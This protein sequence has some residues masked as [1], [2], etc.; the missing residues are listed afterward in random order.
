M[1]IELLAQTEPA[2]GAPTQDLIPA[3]I[4]AVVLSVLV[5]LLTL[6]H[7]SGRITVLHKIGAF[8]TRV[9]GLPPWAAVPAGVVGVSLV[10]AAFGF[11]WDVATHIDNGRDEGPFANPAHFFILAGLGGIA[12]AGILA[13]IIGTDDDAGHTVRIAPGWH[14]PVGGVLLVLCGTIALLGFPLDDV[15]HRLFGQDVTMWGP[16]HLQMI[17][18]ASLA[19]LACWVLVLEGRRT[20]GSG[21]S[22]ERAE[23]TVRFT[24]PL[25]AGAFLI[26]LST[27][28][29]E[30]DFGVPQFRLLY[31]PVLLS[32][33]AGIALVVARVRIG[34]GGALAAVAFFVAFRGALAL[35]IGPGL[36]RSMPHFPLYLVEALAVETVA[37]RVPRERQL[38][39]GL[40]SG[41]LIGTLGVAAEW[42]WSHL[43]MPI[44]WP[45]SLLPEGAVLGFVAGVAGGVLG[46]LLARAL[47]PE[48]LRQPVPRRAG[49]LA[50]VAAVACL[51]IP[52][53]MASPDGVVADVTL[54]DV[55]PGPDRTVEATIAI[56]PADV[57]DGAE[58]LTVTAW[59][60]AEWQDQAVVIDHLERVDEGTW[61]TTEP[62]PVHGKWKAIVRLHAGRT[63][64]AMP[65]FMP[66][67]QAIPAEE[68]PADSAFSRDFVSD[69]ELLQR[70][71]T[72]GA[73]W[74]EWTAYLTILAIAVAWVASIVWGLGRLQH[75]G[76]RV[77]AGRRQTVEAG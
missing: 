32:L 67:D 60:G 58:W 77:R 25:L 37:L 4:V 31:H 74:L 49:A 8:G 30:F 72:G 65:I 12:L 34:R 27:M 10:T 21:D 64:A 45:S 62:I 26:G 47:A 29:G 61:R 69:K 14:V 70:E 20:V 75:M 66:E 2:G 46:G 9:S 33:A 55:D 68:V 15:W 38:T 19:T 24:E 53:P 7:R 42:L 71:Q 36:G 1:L 51:A 23:R 40:W 56:E 39:L 44:P 18:G 52:L 3:S 11:Y 13:V 22:G 73:A 6:G 63:L 35:I 41:V 5:V 59:Q 28:Q 50:G 16:T 48:E 54:R 17:A 57:A 76:A 43:W